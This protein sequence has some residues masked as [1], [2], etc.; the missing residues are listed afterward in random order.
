LIIIIAF[1]AFV[2]VFVGAIYNVWSKTGSNKFD[3]AVEAEFVD[4]TTVGT[5]VVFPSSNSTIDARKKNNNNN[6]NNNKNHTKNH[7]DANTNKHNKG[8]KHGHV[9]SDLLIAF[10]VYVAQE[11]LSISMVYD[12]VQNRGFICP[13]QS[14]EYDHAGKGLVQGGRVTLGFAITATIL[15]FFSVI[16][17][18][19]KNNK[20]FWIS[21][22]AICCCVVCLIVWNVSVD[23]VIRDRCCIAQDCQ[24]GPS[25]GL[26]AAGAFFLLT[27][28][29]TQA[30]IIADDI[31]VLHP[32][33]QYG[34]SK[35]VAT[36]IPLT[37]MGVAQ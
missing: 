32:T 17:L 24:L 20:A 21:L 11:R 1:L 28:C 8:V 19:A 9:N 4:V 3:Q 2:A 13:Y 27:A 6:N 33:F 18:A 22:A 36:V 10:G 29:F 35:Q 23:F 7:H 15:S 31:A 25:Y 12:N 30:W 16:V 14:T 34:D 37:P 5:P 26:I